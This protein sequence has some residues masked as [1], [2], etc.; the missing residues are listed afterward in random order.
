MMAY[1]NCA[2]PQDDDNADIFNDNGY[3][4]F[5]HMNS[6]PLFRNKYY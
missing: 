5:F 2:S 1:I 3:E 4:V 6:S